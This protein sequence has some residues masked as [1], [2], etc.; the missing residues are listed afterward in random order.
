VKGEILVGFVTPERS[1]SR[2]VGLYLRSHK[3]FLGSRDGESTEVPAHKWEGH[4]VVDTECSG[5]YKRR[6]QWP[7]CLNPGEF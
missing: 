2:L 1:H 3:D 5:I 4:I 6:F 7:S